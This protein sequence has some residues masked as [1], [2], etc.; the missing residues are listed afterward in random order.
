M[1][2]ER[3]ELLLPGSAC[4][5]GRL[6]NFSLFSIGLTEAGCRRDMIVDEPSG[7]ARKRC[8]D[9]GDLVGLFRG[10]PAACACNGM[11][12]ETV[13]TELDGQEG[14]Q[15]SPGIAHE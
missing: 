2:R 6:A 13:A 9:D 5:A 1:A 10:V 12:I 11:P 3:I 14:N 8:T 4:D 7:R 15:M